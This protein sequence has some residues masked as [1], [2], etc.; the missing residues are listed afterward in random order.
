MQMQSDM[1]H[2]RSSVSNGLD[3]CCIISR[4]NAVCYTS[5]VPVAH[6]L[7]LRHELCEEIIQLV[8]PLI[9]LTF[10][11][12]HSVNSGTLFTH[13]ADSRVCASRE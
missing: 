10:L 4:C 3:R 9:G 6:L 5:C 1:Q 13:A 7:L 8:H 2:S 11:L 12:A